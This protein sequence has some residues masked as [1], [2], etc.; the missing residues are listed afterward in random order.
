MGAENGCLPF[1]STTRSV[2]SVVD[3]VV[4]PKRVSNLVLKHHG[5]D[6][7]LLAFPSTEAHQPESSVK[8]A[9]FAGSG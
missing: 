2:V 4:G 5:F 9:S 3:D 1:K 6:D 7:Q 8:Q